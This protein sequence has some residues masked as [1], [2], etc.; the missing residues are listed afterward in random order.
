M[1]PEANYSRGGDEHHEARFEI[2][3]Q[4]SMMKMNEFVIIGDEL[5]VRAIEDAS[6]AAVYLHLLDD[7]PAL[8]AERVREPRRGSAVHVHDDSPA[9]ERPQEPSGVRPFRF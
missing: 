7:V 2:T 1:E 6:P 9:A 5:E 3:F 8:A 4:C